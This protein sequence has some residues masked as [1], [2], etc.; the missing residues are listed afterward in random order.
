MIFQ[1][2]LILTLAVGLTLAPAVVTRADEVSKTVSNMI[3]TELGVFV[4]PKAGQDAST[5][6]ND[7]LSCYDSAK[8]RTGIDP[9]VAAPPVQVADTGRGGAV[10]GAAGGAARGAAL[11]AILDDTSKGA[12]VGAAAGAMR[13][14]KGKRKAAAQAEA[15]AEAATAAS[16]KERM[17]TFNR[18][19]GAC[20]DARNY[21]VQ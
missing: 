8:E 1:H 12:A 3:E 14:R 4:F 9:K 6:A 21:S 7:S 15:Q 5:Q 10:R 20:M 19:F 2:R 16:A 13:G 17:S 11:G 18:A